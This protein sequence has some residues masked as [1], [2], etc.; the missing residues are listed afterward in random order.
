MFCSVF[1]FFVG[2]TNINVISNNK[3]NNFKKMLQEE[4]VDESTGEEGIHMHCMSC[5]F[6]SCNQFRRCPIM[7][8]PARCG[9]QC[10]KCKLEEHT[11][12]CTQLKRPCVNSGFGCPFQVTSIELMTHLEVCPANV[13]Y[14]SSNWNRTPLYSMVCHFTIFNVSFI[15]LF[16]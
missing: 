1:V 4:N 11:Q 13:I 7:H 8:C 12:V 6:V 2:F 16:K 3:I 5:H 15:C 10:H 14:C 9:A